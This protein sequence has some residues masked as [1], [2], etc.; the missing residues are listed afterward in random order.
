MTKNWFNTYLFWTKPDPSFKTEAETVW[1]LQKIPLYIQNEQKN[2]K[3][4]DLLIGLKIIPKQSVYC[5]TDFF[6]I[7]FVIQ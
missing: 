3:I 4:T 7:N 2:F 6:T 1:I 5:T